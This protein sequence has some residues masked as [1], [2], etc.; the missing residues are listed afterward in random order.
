MV[1]IHLEEA[2]E[3]LGNS[4][5]LYHK[6]TDGFISKYEHV[7]DEYVRLTAKKDWEE[8]RR[9]AH[10]LKGLCAN[11]GANDLSSISKEL[12]Y[13]YRDQSGGYEEIIVRYKAELLVVI[14]ELR[15]YKSKKVVKPDLVGARTIAPEEYMTLLKE[16]K[17]ALGTFKYS[18][19]KKVYSVIK[20]HDAP[21]S[22]KSIMVKVA[23]AIDGFD[24]K[25]AVEIIE[26]QIGI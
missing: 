16:L 6:L 21:E 4:E 26:T 22:Y 17:A 18:E 10:S 7:T 9:L 15:M 19:I 8:A 1:H 13:A 20:E 3:R 14:E 12:E 23:T 11:I 25:E 2:L 24:Y 5:M